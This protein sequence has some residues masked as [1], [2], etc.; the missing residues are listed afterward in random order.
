MS[1]KAVFMNVNRRIKSY[2]CFFRQT[3]NGVSVQVRSSAQSDYIFVMNFT[4]QNQP[5]LFESLVIDMI[6]G[7]ELFGEVELRKYEVRIVEK[8]INR[9]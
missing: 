4:E 3:R 5:V 7:E 6:T 9:F 1:S 8:S 2:T